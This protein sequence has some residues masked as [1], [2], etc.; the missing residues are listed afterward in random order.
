[1][2]RAYSFYSFGGYKDMYLGNL[3][4]GSPSVYYLPILSIMK[5]RNIAAEEQIVSMLEELPK[6][7]IITRKDSFQFPTDCKTLFSHGSYILMYRTLEDNSVCLAI[8]NLTSSMTDEEG[9]STPYTLL[10]LADTPSDVDILDNVATFCLYNSQKLNDIL[11]PM[12]VYD[13]KVN[14]LRADIGKMFDWIVSCPESDKFI[15]TKGVVDYVMVTSLSYLT[16]VLK[17]HNI[18]KHNINAIALTDGS[19]R[20]GE[21]AIRTCNDEIIDESDTLPKISNPYGSTL[22]EESILFDMYFKRK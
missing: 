14:G 6:I 20:K 3:A 4:G 21:L 13:A 17:E 12:I 1:M 8:R 2:I 18:D 9:R 7:Q 19:I 16:F 22:G 5:K 10:F 15:H 11:S